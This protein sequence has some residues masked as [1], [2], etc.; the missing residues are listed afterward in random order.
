MSNGGGETGKIRR[1]KNKTG[2]DKD[3]EVKRKKR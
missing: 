1:Q 2:E 3:A